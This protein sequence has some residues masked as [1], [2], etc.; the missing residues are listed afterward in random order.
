MNTIDIIIGAGILIFLVLFWIV[1]FKAPMGYQ[2]E[3][4]FHYGKEPPISKKDIEIGAPFD[5]DLNK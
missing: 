5:E 3:K 1:I 2:D 4:G